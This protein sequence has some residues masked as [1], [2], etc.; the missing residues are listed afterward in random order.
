MACGVCIASQLLARVDAVRLNPHVTEFKTG[1][2]SCTVVTPSAG[3]NTHSARDYGSQ[4][5][6]LV[7]V[8]ARQG[9]VE[10]M[11]LRLADAR[12]QTQKR[13]YRARRQTNGKGA[14]VTKKA[15]YRKCARRQAVTNTGEK[16]TK[17]MT[18]KHGRRH[19]HRENK[20][21]ERRN[22]KA[23]R[24]EEEHKRALPRRKNVKTASFASFLQ[25]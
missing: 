9:Q 4:T 21:T 20:Y 10:E 15:D 22:S 7:Y 24:Q 14:Q 16:G 2:K 13:S 8:R 11:H 18:S 5:L 17:I 3:T 25:P 23:Q 12:R 6:V 19:W 1:L